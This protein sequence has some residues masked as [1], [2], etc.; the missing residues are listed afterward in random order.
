[1]NAKAKSEKDK[2]KE[3]FDKGTYEATKPYLKAAL[4]QL[5]KAGRSVKDFLEFAVGR[6]GGAIVPYVKKFEQEV[7]EGTV[8]VAGVTKSTKDAVLGQ[9]PFETGKATLRA[10]KNTA[11]KEIHVVKDVVGDW[12]AKRTGKAPV[13]KAAVKKTA[14]KR[15]ATKKKAAAKKAAPK[16]KAAS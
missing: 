15:P 14:A 9:S 12:V 16:K 1:M 10:V 4:E 2:K 7:R 11:E 13:K 5:L 3:R 6:F 8:K